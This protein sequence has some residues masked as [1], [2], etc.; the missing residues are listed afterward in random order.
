MKALLF[1]VVSAVVV[2]VMWTAPAAA[3]DEPA[4][5]FDGTNGWACPVTT[6]PDPAFVPPRPYPASPTHGS[7]WYGT[8]ELWTLLGRTVWQS[9]SLPHNGNGYR[10]KIFWW[11]PGFNGK[12]EPVP[13]LSVTGRRLDGPGAF[14]NP[15]PATNASSPDFGGWAMLTGVDIPAPGCWELTGEYHGR[16]L[17]FVVLVE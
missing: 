13:A 7:Y 14:V 3:R 10:Q 9:H 16:S 12:T 15:L 8:P 6:R 4:A 1:G 11:R 2:L 5:R 17:S